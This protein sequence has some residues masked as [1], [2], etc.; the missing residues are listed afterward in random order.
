MIRILLLSLDS[1]W[2][3]QLEKALHEESLSWDVDLVQS[4]KEA[5]LKLEEEIYD[6]IVCDHKLSKVRGK[7]A[8]QQLAESF[9]DVLRLLVIPKKE[10]EEQMDAYMGQHQ[11]VNYPVDFKDII[12]Q[13]RRS[14]ELRKLLQS[15]RVSRAV[16]KIKKLPSYP[17][18]FSQLRQLLSGEYFMLNEVADIVQKDT[19]MVAKVLQIANSAFFG[20]RQKV[21]NI[22]MAVTLLGVGKIKSLVLA[23][24]IFSQYD[25]NQLFDY[26]QQ[27]EHSMHVADLCV[28]LAKELNLS[29]KQIEESYVV[30]IIHDIGKLALASSLPEDYDRALSISEEQQIPLI[31]AER[32]V[33]EADHAA[34]GA[35][36]L[37]LWG[38]PDSMVEA[39]AYH[40]APIPGKKTQ[41]DLPEIVFLANHLAHMAEG[42]ELKEQTH[43]LLQQ[44]ISHFNL[45]TYFEVWNEKLTKPL[46]HSLEL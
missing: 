7:K 16:S 4:V 14:K 2:K 1:N 46:E 11:V 3:S 42:R 39:V 22:Q 5:Q 17:E 10:L 12:E 19:A 35:F 29:E 8:L 13:I 37:S 40:H 36:V 18:I 15:D 33:F 31:Q 45:E 21:T 27:W 9:P 43:V 25:D 44:V 34:I 24:E 26:K 30:G 38:L 6:A 28:K 20:L 32:V 41:C 23:H